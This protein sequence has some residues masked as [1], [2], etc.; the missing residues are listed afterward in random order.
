MSNA[1]QPLSNLRHSAYSI[2][3]TTQFHMFAVQWGIFD[4]TSPTSPDSVFAT[5]FPTIP[6]HVGRGDYLTPSHYASLYNLMCNIRSAHSHGRINDIAYRSIADRFNGISEIAASIHGDEE[7]T[8]AINEHYANKSKPASVQSTSVQSTS[9]Q[10]STLTSHANIDKKT[11]QT[12]SLFDDDVIAINNANY[13]NDSAIS[14]NKT[15]QPDNRSYTLLPC[16]YVKCK[17]PS[18]CWHVCHDDGTFITFTPLSSW[19]DDDT[20]ML[21]AYA[22]PFA[23]CANAINGN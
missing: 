14:I 8:A 11:S 1:S 6:S 10:N 4:A 15:V 3:A 20:L 19:I 17:Q 13:D 18:H 7:L 21:T 16:V 2:I 12:P 22:D 5:P 23:D 9:T